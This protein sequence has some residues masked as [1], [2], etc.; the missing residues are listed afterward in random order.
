M[1]RPDIV[2]RLARALEDQRLARLDGRS[3]GTA[4]AE[5]RALVA[6]AAAEHTAEELRATAI[7]VVEQGRGGSLRSLYNLAFEAHGRRTRAA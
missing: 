1:I 3:L 4:L 2:L 6:E 7:N 5:Y